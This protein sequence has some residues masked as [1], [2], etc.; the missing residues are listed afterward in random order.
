[1][2]VLLVEPDVVLAKAYRAALEALDIV[3]SVVSSAQAAVEAVDAGAPDCVVLELQLAGH[4][5]VEFLHEF[6]SYEDWQHIPVVAYSAVPREA[7]GVAESTWERFGVS[8]YLYKNDVSASQMAAI[9]R[10]L[11][12]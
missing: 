10:A 1:M 12:P 3:V 4:S 11:G 7:F 5:G 2:Y 9:V 6:R 8:R